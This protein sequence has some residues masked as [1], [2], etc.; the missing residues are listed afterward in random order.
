[1]NKQVIVRSACL[2][3]FV[4]LAGCA[5]GGPGGGSIY[6]PVGGAMTAVRRRNHHALIFLKSRT[7]RYGARVSN[8]LSLS[9]TRRAPGAQLQR[10]R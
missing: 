10:I 4:G 3:L 9:R 7:N 5:T 1:M 6:V 8:R 2:A